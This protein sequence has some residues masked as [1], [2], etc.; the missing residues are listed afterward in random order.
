VP[1]VVSTS[2][3][4]T[5]G[6]SAAPTYKTVCANDGH[7]EAIKIEFDPATISY[8]ELMQRVFQQAV[9]P[10][11]RGKRQY[12]SAVWAIDTEQE[13]AAKKVAASLNKADV[14]VLAP[15][16]WYDAEEYHQK[17]VEKMRR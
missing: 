1:G 2:V 5:G 13:A 7:T 8:E 6:T 14:P 16:V 3:G 10:A 12:M 15:T 11:P 9:P 4:Y 17:Y